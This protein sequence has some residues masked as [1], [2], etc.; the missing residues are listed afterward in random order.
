MQKCLWLVLVELAASFSRLSRSPA[1]LT[2][3]SLVFFSIW[4]FEVILRKGFFSYFKGK[5]SSVIFL[6]FEFFGCFV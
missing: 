1:S 4:V 5:G 3:T 2:F 6:G